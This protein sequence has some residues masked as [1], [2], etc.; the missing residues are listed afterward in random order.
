MPHPDSKHFYCIMGFIM[1]V[2]LLLTELGLSFADTLDNNRTYC[3]S[4]YL[5]QYGYLN[6]SENGLVNVKPTEITESLRFFQEYYNISDGSGQLDE[7]TMDFMKKPRCGV[8]DDFAFSI[9][10]YKWRKNVIKWHYSLVNETYTALAKKAFD[11]WAEVTNISF[12]HNS[13]TPDI[14][15]RNAFLTHKNFGPGFCTMKFDGS[16]G[17]LAHADYPRPNGELIEIHIDQDEDWYL[18]FDRAE[19]KYSLLA[20]LIHEIGHSLGIAH[21]NYKNAIMY[22]AYDELNYRID[23]HEDDILAVQY[24]Y[25]RPVEKKENDTRNSTKEENGEVEGRDVGEKIND[26][27]PKLCEL[28]KIDKFLILNH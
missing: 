15:I 6:V 9:K 18:G 4:S 8:A 2:L 22:S 13:K 21:S 5:Q 17:Q 16:G 12:E 26:P 23:L 3:I 24:I 11:T 7:E 10:P 27:P 19:R 1:L 25:G 20:T 14:V 28:K